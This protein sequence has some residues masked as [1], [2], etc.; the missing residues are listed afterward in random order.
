MS[1]RQQGCLKQSIFF[2]AEL[3]EMMKDDEQDLDHE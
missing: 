2:E 3:N 1:S